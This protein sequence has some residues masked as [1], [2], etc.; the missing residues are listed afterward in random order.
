MRFNIDKIFV[1]SIKN[2]KKRQ[3]QIEE[4]LK[5]IP[6]EW[7]YVEKDNENPKRGCYN[8]HAGVLKLA[9]QRNYN[10]ILILEDD[11][12]L[13]DTWENIIKNTNI[14][15]NSPPKDW[16]FFM[17]GYLP[18]RVSKTQNKHILKMI[19]SSCAHAY[20]VNVNNVSLFPEWNGVLNDIYLFYNKRTDNNIYGLY[21]MGITQRLEDSNIAKFHIEGM[22]LLR[23][24]FR[25]ENNL[26]EVSSKIDIIYL[27]VLIIL[28][29]FLTTS[30]IVVNYFF[31]KNKNINYVF[32]GM[33]V[34][35]IIIMIIIIFADAIKFNKI[36]Y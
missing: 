30:S 9:K 20:I 34:F 10:K 36:I 16:K 11:I 14:F 25:G 13:N 4:I 19:S 23:K 28:I 21:P 18:I 29:L 15:L 32:M 12:K 3:N 17:V 8:S 2:S 22:A 1:I 6:F 27:A 35:M 5:N 31:H 24:L 33:S 7:Y 26:V